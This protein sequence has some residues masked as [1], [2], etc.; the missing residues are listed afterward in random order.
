LFCRHYRQT[1]HIEDEYHVCFECPLYE[2]PRYFLFHQLSMA[3]FSFANIDVQPLNLLAALLSVSNPQHVRAVSKFLCEC[4][5]M[6]VL[7]GCDAPTAGCCRP[8]VG[9]WLSHVTDSDRA[10]MQ[11]CIE[12]AVL[13]FSVHVDELL[14]A[15][16]NLRLPQPMPL[17]SFV[18]QQ[19]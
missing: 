12:D 1:S 16:F 13:G 4:L 19:T 9:N 3:Y 10:R 5:A 8:T 11:R 14:L 6:R 17:S 15:R 2:L 18:S 7:A